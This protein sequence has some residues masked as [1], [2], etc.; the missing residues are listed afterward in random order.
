MTKKIF[1]V[2]TGIVAAVLFVLALTADSQGWT[3]TFCVG[4]IAAAF[5]SLDLAFG[6]RLA[7]WLDGVVR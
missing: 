3:T 6:D 7:R 2:A 5:C 1:A 4:Y